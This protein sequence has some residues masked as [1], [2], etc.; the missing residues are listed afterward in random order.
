MTVAIYF[1]SRSRSDTFRMPNE[2]AD[3]ML[4]RDDNFNPTQLT[5]SSVERHRQSWLLIEKRNRKMM[6]A[7]N[8]SKRR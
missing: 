4:I 2:D 6:F 7:K 8:V 3:S 1:I 5:S